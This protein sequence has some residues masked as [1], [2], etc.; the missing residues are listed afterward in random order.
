[1]PELYDRVRYKKFLEKE[2]SGIIGGEV[3]YGAHRWFVILRDDGS[4]DECPPERI[5]DAE[6]N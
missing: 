6:A 3:W 1:M 4:E 5:L 2:K